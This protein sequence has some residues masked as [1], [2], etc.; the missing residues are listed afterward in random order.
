MLQDVN[1]Q[2]RNCEIDAPTR[3]HIESKLQSLEKVWS[4]LD[5]AEVRVRQERGF[6]IAEITLHA[7][8]L[9][10]RAEERNHNLQ[11]AF[12]ATIHKLQ[13]QLKRYKDKVQH[14]AR[15]HNNRDD[16][17]GVITH[18]KSDG[19]APPTATVAALSVPRLNETEAQDF[20]D[21]AP[22]DFMA[23]IDGNEAP[24]N[25]V[26]AKQF[27]LKPMSP[28]E[29]ALQMDMLGHDFFVFR[30]AKNNGV[31]VVYRRKG[32]GYGWIEPVSD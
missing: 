3:A 10:T 24:A 28:D 22:D 14:R 1:V 9:I 6:Y 27:A 32:G 19:A 18:P 15:R 4:R 26:R 16:V 13:S 29:A 11:Q 5:D 30:N 31:E 21:E 23:G 17:N 2:A 25:L 12:D 8:G 7:G 20:V